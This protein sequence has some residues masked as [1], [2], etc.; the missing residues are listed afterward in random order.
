MKQF[1]RLQ[2][3]VHTESDEVYET[4]MADRIDTGTRQEKP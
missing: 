2:A 3:I 4:L 1:R